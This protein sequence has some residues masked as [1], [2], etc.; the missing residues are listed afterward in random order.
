MACVHGRVFF[1]I[2]FSFILTTCVVFVSICRVR[3]LRATDV[4]VVLGVAE[5]TK[6]VPQGNR[7]CGI[8]RKRWVLPYTTLLMHGLILLGRESAFT[9]TT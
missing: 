2:F 4:R 5:R 6:Y 8:S 3:A 1:F 9:A 7:R